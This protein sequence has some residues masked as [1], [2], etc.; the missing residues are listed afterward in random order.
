M[1]ADVRSN[2]I[3]IPELIA[4]LEE[5]D[6][7]RRFEIAAD[8]LG[9]ARDPRA[10]LPLLARL[11]DPLVQK[12]EHVEDA[13]C[14]ALVALGVM[15]TYGAQRYALLPRY[16]LEPDVVTTLTELGATVPLRYFVAQR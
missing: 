5:T 11:G 1:V 6:D 8:L 7:A 4:E 13:V 9:A 14:A 15:R 16:M 12:N 10:V 2:V 3:A